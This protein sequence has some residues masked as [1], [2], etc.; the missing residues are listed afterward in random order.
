MVPFIP[1]SIFLKAYLI[2]GLNFLARTLRYSYNSCVFLLQ[3]VILDLSYLLLILPSKRSRGVVRWSGWVCID[4]L[5]EPCINPL[6][7]SS[8]IHNCSTYHPL[9]ATFIFKVC[10]KSMC[11]FLDCGSLLFWS[12]DICLNYIQLIKYIMNCDRTRLLFA[13]FE[14]C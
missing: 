10:L 12:L 1:F 5:F 4:S 6:H 3:Y 14:H 2:L 8:H 11:I 13:K 7:F 9:G